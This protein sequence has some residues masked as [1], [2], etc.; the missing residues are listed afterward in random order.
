MTIFSSELK[1]AR[2]WMQTDQLNA[3]LR[4]VPGKGFQIK[5]T[6]DSAVAGFTDTGSEA[7]LIGIQIGDRCVSDLRA[8]RLASSVFDLIRL[9]CR[10]VTVNGIRTPN[11][12][13]LGAAAAT[14]L[15]GSSA[16]F[17]FENEGGDISGRMTNVDL[18]GDESDDPSVPL[19]RRRYEEVEA[20]LL[21]IWPGNEE[22]A[23][24]RST[25]LLRELVSAEMP[26]AA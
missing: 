26:S 2:L 13:S 20:E 4:K 11:L 14:V 23:M 15:D 10:I 8:P 7:E 5:I 19:K 25:E 18:T 12:R 17:C 3:V 16:T 6:K 24:R 21:N 22:G 9:C 1:L